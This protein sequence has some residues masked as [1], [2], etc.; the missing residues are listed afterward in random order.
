MAFPCRGRILQITSWSVE[1][2]SVWATT[3]VYSLGR[4]VESSS[5]WARPGLA[6]SLCRANH[7]KPCL[8]GQVEGPGGI[9]V[10]V[11]QRVLAVKAGAGPVQIGAAGPF[12][13]FIFPAV[14]NPPDVCRAVVDAG[15]TRRA[16]SQAY[17]RHDG[18]SQ[19]KVLGS[20]RTTVFPRDRPPGKSVY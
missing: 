5:V 10:G 2:G 13:I 6:E 3:L 16:G 8:K 18:L 12:T 19:I 1:S 4:S 14:Q 15:G 7:P 9:G 20:I 11:E 17:H